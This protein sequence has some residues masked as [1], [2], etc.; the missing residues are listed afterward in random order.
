MKLLRSIY[1]KEQGQLLILSAFIILVFAS[2]SIIP[3]LSFM[4]TGIVT[5]KNTGFH[6]QEIYAAEAG[7]YDSIWKLILIVP[8]VP[9]S[10]WDPP[11]QY[12]INGG[13]NGKSVDIT[14]TKVNSATYRIHSVATD[15][16]TSHQS[17]IDSDI[18]IDNAGGVDL[19]AFSKYALT[20]NGT[21]TG[22]GSDIIYGDVWIPSSANYSAPPP[23]GQL[24]TA[25][26]VG[27]P[28][29]SELET[30][31]SCLVDTSNAYSNGIINVSNPNQSGPLYA[32]GAS[33]GDYT[34]T[35]TGN[36]TGTIY[37]DGN[38]D[39]NNKAHI[40]LAGNTIFV[41]GHVSSSPQAYLAGPGAVI[42]LGD[43]VFSPQV[44]PSYIFIMSLSGSVQFQP[45]GNFIGA[46][47]GDTNINLQP[48][49]T[50]T[51]QSP[52]VGNLDLPGLY[53]HIQKFM[54]W[55]IR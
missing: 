31:F 9:K 38:L 52:G 1:H 46:V 55:T 23:S 51:W 25:P 41:T 45:Q 42:A 40:S 14:L 36:L 7:V 3:I 20:S 6:T 28:T 34:I 29:A 27:W 53:N 17:T 18:C 10:Q 47:C 24:I 44:A 8:G 26:I 15:P 5:A 48:N 35:G 37:V 39:F 50:L 13:V 16:N 21:I 4:G 43:I 54:T 11:L 33:N 49:C 22:K 19:S 2:L 30:Y 12:S 32:Q